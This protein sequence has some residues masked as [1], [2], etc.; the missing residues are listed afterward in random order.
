MRGER[1]RQLGFDHL[2]QLT[3]ML[4]QAVAHDLEGVE[5]VAVECG[6]DAGIENRKTFAVKKSADASKQIALIGR[7]HQHLDA[8]AHRREAGADDGLI[9]KAF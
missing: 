9:F 7:V 3:V 8:F 4:A 5:R 1:A 2:H 6:V